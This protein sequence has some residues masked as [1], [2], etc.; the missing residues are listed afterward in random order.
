MSRIDKFKVSGNVFDQ[1]TEKNLWE[2]ITHKK[3]EGLE[4]PIKLGKEANIFSALDPKGKRLAVKIYRVSA[5]DFFKMRRYLEVDTRFKLKRSRKAIVDIW[6]R[7]E[8]SN[9]TKAHNHK[10]NV[11][12]PIAIFNN[13]LIMEFIGN[14]SKE[15]IPEASPLLKDSRPK[16][17]TKFFREIVKN[18]K[19]LYKANIIHGDLSE[20]NIL[21]DKEK[22]ILIDL[23]HGMPTNSNVSEEMLKR[24]I[25]NISRYFKK[26]GLIIDEDK[27]I[28]E[29]KNKRKQIKS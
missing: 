5:C 3:I 27:L 14:K 28:K 20:F 11:P 25:I 16:N 1:N 12:K 18:I 4:S 22:P 23:S 15:K 24:D 17:P 10:V 8:F 7:R 21:N 26:L 19:L 9:L 6:A 13:V 2:L 29:I